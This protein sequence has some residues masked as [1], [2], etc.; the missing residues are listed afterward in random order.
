MRILILLLLMAAYSHGGTAVAQTERQ[1]QVAVSPTSTPSVQPTIEV[2]ETQID[3]NQADR[4]QSITIVDERSPWP[5]RIANIISAI[6]VLF[7]LYQAYINRGMLKSMETNEGLLESQCKALGELAE[8]TNKQFTAMENQLTEMG[9]QTA[10]AKAQGA[11]LE[12]QLIAMQEAA[13]M[14]KGQLVAL[15]HQEQAQFSNLDETRKIVGQNA[16]VVKAMQG[17]LAAMEQQTEYAQRAYLSV[18]IANLGMAQEITGGNQCFI[19]VLHI[20]NSGNTPAYNVEIVVST[21]MAVDPPDPALLSSTSVRVNAGWL[22][23]ILK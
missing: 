3:G 5:S 19:F 18:P 11:V 8:A 17:Q 9:N 2:R 12:G 7:V 1:R 4:G 10:V 16:D 13:D 22:G 23:L 6:L 14:A 21:G 20:R 15:Q